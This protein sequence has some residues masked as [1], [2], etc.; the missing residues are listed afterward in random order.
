MLYA[1]RR[2]T[3]PHPVTRTQGFA[4]HGDQD[5]D[6]KYILNPFAFFASFAVQFFY[7]TGLEI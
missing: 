4:A 7:K 2:K 1:E 6:T 3:G 5:M